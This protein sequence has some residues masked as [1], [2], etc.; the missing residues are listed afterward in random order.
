MRIAIGIPVFQ[1]YM[2][3]VAHDYMR[4]LYSFGKRMPEHDFYLIPKT[5]SEQFR[6]RNAIVSTALQFACDY[7]LFLDDDHVFDW[8][9]I[10]NSESYTFLSKL[11]EHDKDIVGCLYYHRTGSYRPVLMKDSG[12]AGDR[13]TFLT[14]ADITGELQEVDVQGGGVMLVNMKIFDELKPPY[15]EPEMQTDGE[16]LGTD[17]QL[18]RKAK[19][20]G[21]KVWCDTSIV[22]G[23]MKQEREVVHADNRDSFIADNAVRAGTADDWLFDNWLKGYRDDV[24][25]Y[26]GLD[27]ETILDHAL[28]YREGMPG[29]DTYD[30]P[31]D[32]YRELGFEQICRQCNYHSRP[33]VAKEGLTI[34]KQ[35]KRGFV[36]Y[37]LDFGCGSAPVGFEMLKRG[38]RMDFVD[39][40][41]AG[42]YEFLKWRVAKSD[43]REQ[44][45]YSLNGPYDFLFF[46]D[47]IEHIQDW[48]AV[49][50]EALG[51]LSEKGLLI[52]NYFNN[53]DYNN[54]EHI[55]MDHGA[56]A[57][58]LAS[59]NMI[60]MSN[61]VWFKDDNFMG[62][63]MQTRQ[64]DIFP[65]VSEQ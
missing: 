29:I 26:T 41:G 33:L 57:E 22:V 6:A 64:P 38:H 52:T 10:P 54:R 46:L 19:E 49:L 62:G 25:E 9:G 17:I 61:T 5:K 4:M 16:S 53:H 18:C 23:H 3:E 13:Y 28:H 36:G 59:R 44:V 40:D 34:L 60:P 32:Y 35:F 45:G 7:L 21:F 2:P 58:F 31:K 65:K 14:D 20:A 43:Y 39:L 37:G 47:A 24:R 27:N 30:D 63:A 56:V 8:K 12:K 50:D 15:F 11:L 1:N 42:A 55:S 51:R 48:E